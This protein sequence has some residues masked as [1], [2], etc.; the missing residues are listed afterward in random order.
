MSYKKLLLDAKR[1][2]GKAGSGAHQRAK[3]LV[4]VFNDRDF[5]ADH[6]NLDD[7]QAADQLD[8]YVADLCLGFLE[9]KAMLE[10]FPNEDRWKKGDLK[11]MHAEMLAANRPA[12]QRDDAPRVR[13]TVKLAEFDQVAAEKRRYETQATSYAS[14]LTRLREKVV[15]LEKERDLLRNE[16][17]SA[18]QRITEL[19]EM[20]ENEPA[21]A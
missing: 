15:A 19:Q 2:L 9:L 8:Q 20:L 13:R 1:L 7:F 3:L 14:E 21:M 17:Q 11:R 6:G 5:R 18:E 16:L 10:H 12:P 4:A